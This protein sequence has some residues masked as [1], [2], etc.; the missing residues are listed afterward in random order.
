[1]ARIYGKGRMACIDGGESMAASGWRRVDGGKLMVANLW[2][3]DDGGE[4]MAANWWR[5][6]MATAG[7]RISMAVS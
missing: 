4:L 6:F 7:W 2:R 3:R 1:M 5:G